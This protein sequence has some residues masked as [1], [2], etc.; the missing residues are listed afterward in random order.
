MFEA[1]AE[2]LLF[3]V[4]E[5]AAGEAGEVVAAGKE[6][7]YAWK[8]D[9]ISANIESEWEGTRFH[10]GLG[11]GVVKGSLSGIRWWRSNFGKFRFEVD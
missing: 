4:A 1:R 5:D 10:G 3:L 8:V 7:G 2:I 9:D 11:L 6:A